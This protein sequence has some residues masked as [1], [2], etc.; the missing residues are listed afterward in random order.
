MQK[1]KRNAKSEMDSTL[2]LYDQPKMHI[3]SH[4]RP[5]VSPE[6]IQLKW[7]LKRF[8]QANPISVTSLD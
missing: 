7:S 4:R 3:C 8:Y 6:R 5:K 1:I 2:V